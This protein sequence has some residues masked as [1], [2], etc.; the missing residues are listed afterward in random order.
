MSILD[1]NL[2]QISE[3][4]IS[5]MQRQKMKRIVVGTQTL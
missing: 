4:K 3:E 5:E 1:S 2:Q